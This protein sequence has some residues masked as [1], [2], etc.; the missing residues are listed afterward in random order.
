MAAP[1]IIGRFFMRKETWIVIMF[2]LII[3]GIYYFGVL[4]GKDKYGN[5]QTLPLPDG[6]MS[7]PA[8]WSA[9]PVVFQLKSAMEG[10]GT[11][12]DM[13]WSALNGLTDDQ[14][15]AVYNEFSNQ[16]GETLFEWFNDDLSGDDLA[17]ATGYFIGLV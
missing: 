12:T 1:A 15:V 3:A 16:V 11:D 7:I 2:L 5:P 8:G 4:K 6:G 17:R 10:W 13:I 9:T 14:L